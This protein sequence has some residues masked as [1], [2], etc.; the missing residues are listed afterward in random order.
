MTP[1]EARL[2]RKYV[3]EGLEDEAKERFEYARA[4]LRTIARR[5]SL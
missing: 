1:P 5:P 4:I 3:T 2:V